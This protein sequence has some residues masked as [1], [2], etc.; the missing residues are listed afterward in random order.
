VLERHE[1]IPIQYFLRRVRF[2]LGLKLELLSYILNLPASIIR[3]FLLL[4]FRAKT[5]SEDAF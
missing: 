4:L 5:M 2:S 3:T 1:N